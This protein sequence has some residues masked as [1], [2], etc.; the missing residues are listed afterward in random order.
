MEYTKN[1]AS[2]PVLCYTDPL[3]LSLSFCHH[4]DP[5]LSLSFSLSCHHTDTLSQPVVSRVN[6]LLSQIHNFYYT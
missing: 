1:D 3:S 2:L 4:T 6:S 5:L